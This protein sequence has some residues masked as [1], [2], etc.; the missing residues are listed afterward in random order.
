MD[1]KSLELAERLTPI[2]FRFAVKKRDEFVKRKGKFVHYTSAENAIKI[3]KSKEV[4]LRSAR[5][6][7]D[8]MEVE[9]GYQ[10]LR[11]FFQKDQFKNRKFLYDVVDT[12]CKGAAQEA[13]KKF[14]ESWLSILYDTYL[15]CF[16]EH[17]E[18]ENDFG[19]LSMW[20]AYGRS[21]VGVGI[22]LNSAPFMLK[23]NASGVFASPV[24][25]LSEERFQSALLETIEG[26][27][28]EREFLSSVPR[29]HIVY[30]LFAMLLFAAVCSKHPG[31]SEEREWRAVS[32][33]KLYSAKTLTSSI[34]TISGVPQ[35]VY[36]FPLRD[37]PEVGLIGLEIPALVDRV[38]IGPSNF[39][40]PVLNAIV[41]SLAEAGVKDAAK[42]VVVSN[43][44]L[45]T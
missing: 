24:S 4:W 3:A 5:A 28:D 36:R 30:S 41:A 7:N 40:V 17:D 9:H 42:K 38:I 35:L 14:D 32:V 11:N 23:T 2:F 21:S 8:F 13:I 10:Y 1:E 31:F 15:S 25:Y 34:E 22:V 33:P 37:Q 16:S 29:L 27:A 44:P 39:P 26:F 43:I 18:D 6:M 19:R 45:R 12:F 20:R